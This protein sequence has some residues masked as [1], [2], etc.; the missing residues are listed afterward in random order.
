MKN[1]IY[2]S[3]IIAF[4]IN[5]LSCKSESED[6]LIGKFCYLNY[7]NNGILF[8]NKNS[9]IW[10]SDI[11]KASRIDLQ[12]NGDEKNQN[13]YSEIQFKQDHSYTLKKRG[14][15]IKDSLIGEKENGTT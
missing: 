1:K 9:K 5:V 14:F 11:I 15:I 8:T 6:F 4:F 2:Y 12:M 7:D 3:L 10:T 13:Y